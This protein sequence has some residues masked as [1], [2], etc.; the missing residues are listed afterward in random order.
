MALY[1][2]KDLVDP[3]SVS[4]IPAHAS[5]KAVGSK[6]LSKKNPFAYDA[7]ILT[8]NEGVSIPLWDGTKWRPIILKDGDVDFS[9]AALLDAGDALGFGKDYYVYLCVDGNSPEIVVSLNSTYPDGSTALTSRRI[10]GFHYGTIRKVSDDD[11]WIPIDS[12]GNK[13][14]SSGTKWQDNVTEGIVPNSVWDLIHRP[15]VIATGMA[16]VHGIWQ[17]IYI[18]SAE[19]TISFMASTN[20]LPVAEGKLVSKYG[21][22]PVTGTEGLS[23]FN[24]N[25]LAHKQGMRLLRYNEWLAGAFGS[26]QGEDDSNNYGWTKTTNTGKTYTGCQVNTS[27]G[28]H[29]ISSGVKPYAVSAYNL[30]DCAGNVSEWTGDYSIRQDS[31]SWSWQN[32]LGSNQGQAYLPNSDGLVTLLCGCHWNGGVLCGPR[33]VYLNYYPWYVLAYIGAR[34]ACDA[35]A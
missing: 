23:Q 30:C 28:E 13:W 15:R 34:L 9:P 18:A 29:D 22:L 35:A 8:L 16:E 14:G 20:N 2:Y 17:G 33:A 31:T 7:N 25:E 12:A 10:G 24:F 1:E 26:P 3:C 5:V 21:A 27:T 4:L 32:V 19:E 6:F 11:K